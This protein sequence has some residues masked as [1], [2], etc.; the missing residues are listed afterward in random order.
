MKP[1]SNYCPV[2]DRIVKVK[3]NKE[4]SEKGFSQHTPICQ[5]EKKICNGSCEGCSL[6]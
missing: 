4:E 1:V 2:L 5:T 6:M 3:S